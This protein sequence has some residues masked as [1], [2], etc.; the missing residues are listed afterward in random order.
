MHTPT[1]LAVL[2]LAALAAPATAAP[3]T[4]VAGL[5]PPETIAYAELAD[6]AAAAP[7]VAALVM[8]SVIEDS[9]GFIHK[10]RDATKNP[11]DIQ[12]KQDLAVL[13]LLAS[14]EMLA[15]F[16]KLRGVG[17]GLVGFTDTGDPQVALAVL[18]G[19]SAAGVA[20]RAFLTMDPQVRKVAAIGDVPVYQFRQVNVTNDPM[21]R[22]ILQDGKL[23]EGPY[24]PTFAYL[25]GLIVVGTSR[26]ALTPVVERFQ[27]KAKGT[28]GE[29][30]LFKEAAATNRRPGVFAFANVP[31]FCTKSDA[32]LKG[33]NSSG[34]PDLL[35]WCKLI[36]D[37]RSMRYLVGSVRVRDN[38]LSLEL[39]GQFEPAKKSPLL[40]LLA[41]PGVKVELLHHAP[42][43]AS[44]A[45]AVTFPE[46]D[47]AGAVVGFLDAL[48]KANGGLGR[49][50]S[51]AV[52]ELEAKYKLSIADGLLAKTRAAVVVLPATQELPKGA[53]ALPTVVLHTDTPEVAAAWEAFLP[54]LLGDLAGANPTEPSSEAVGGVKVLSLPGTGLPWKAAVHYARKDT[55][56]AVGLDRKVVA[57][58]LL[59]DPAASVAADQSV[60]STGAFLGTVNLGVLVRS[61]FE[62]PKH[63]GPVKPVKPSG[64]PRNGGE[65][66]V[67][68]EHQDKD[69]EQAWEGF[70]KSF[71]SLP[72][73]VLTARRT[74]TEVRI[75]LWQPKAAEGGLVPVVNAGLA[76][77]DVVL[78]REA[79]PNGG[80]PSRPYRR[81]KR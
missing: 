57:A 59:A 33:R 25:P 78:N 5:F 13:G 49:L 62:S 14:P 46:K 36:A 81:F 7:Q 27:G 34:E 45:I 76:W 61:A 68:P 50:P 11:A 41:G 29:T 6:P 38:G 37:H 73:A 77:F 56:I 66:L 53:I 8:G 10:R 4:D 21:G 47:R 18:T 17:V 71:D 35:A 12:G 42:R 44:L 79:S 40:D 15:E 67:P 74:G 16:K 20:A 75:E 65:S 54:K 43:P 80:G 58:A 64:P 9:I 70:L 1:R 23:T 28:L 22:L 52:K 2:L 39:V 69:E 55:V 26:A 31:A 72:P 48:V 24:E 63:E 60:S 3:P 19:D 32:A 51:E 30:P